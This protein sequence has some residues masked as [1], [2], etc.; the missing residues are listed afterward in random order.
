ML[1]KVDSSTPTEPSFGLPVEEQIKP[2]VYT[3][4][5]FKKYLPYLLSA[6]IL[7]V[8]AVLSFSLYQQ[9]SPQKSN[10]PINQITTSPAGQ[11][12]STQGTNVP[13]NQTIVGQQSLPNLPLSIN[14]VSKS[15]NKIT[16]KVDLQ[17]NSDISLGEVYLT[18]YLQ[19]PDEMQIASASGK[20]VGSIKEGKIYSFANTIKPFKLGFGEKTSQTIILSYSSNL[21]PNPDYKL[22]VF[23][24]GKYEQI[25]GS[26]F[27]NL[28]L[29]GTD[30]FLTTGNCRVIAEG[31]EYADTI[32]A[33]LI[34]PNTQ[35]QAKCSVTNPASKPIT[36]STNTDYAV[37]QVIG[38]PFSQ[39]QNMTDPIKF[40]LNPKETKEITVTLPKMSQPQ[41]YDSLITLIDENNQAVSQLLEFRWTIRGQ[42][43]NIE[44]VVL[45][46]SGYKAGDTAHLAVT[47]AASMDLWWKELKKDEGTSITNAKLTLSLIDQNNQVCGTKEQPLP[48]RDKTENWQI[49]SEIEITTDC[50]NPKVRA[51]IKNDSTVLASFS[52]Q[53]L[54]TKTKSD[55]PISS[56]LDSTKKNSALFLIPL[57][58]GV[59]LIVI[60]LAIAFTR[61][62]LFIISF[63]ALSFL[64]ISYL[65][66]H[67]II[68]A[69]PQNIQTSTI[70]SPQDRD[71]KASAGIQSYQFWKDNSKIEFIDP[72]T[73][74]LT[75]FY[76]AAGHWCNNSSLRFLWK[77]EITAQG[78]ILTLNDQL[79]YAISPDGQYFNAPAQD[80]SKFGNG[81]WQYKLGEDVYTITALN[82]LDKN[83]TPYSSFIDL[84]G[85]GS[86]GSDDR[87]TT[88]VMIK[89]IYLKLPTPII[90]NF[91]Q[92]FIALYDHN[93]SGTFTYEGFMENSYFEHVGGEVKDTSGK[94][95]PG[96]KMV[97]NGKE[98]T[99]DDKGQFYADYFV[100][101]GEGYSVR[102]EP[103]QGEF[104]TPSQ[105]PPSLASFEWQVAGEAKTCQKGDQCPGGIKNC[106]GDCHFVI[107]R[108][109]PPPSGGDSNPPPSSNT[110]QV[111]PP[112]S[113]NPASS[114]PA[115]P[116]P[117]P[118]P[119]GEKDP[120]VDIGAQLN[121]KTISIFWK[122]SDA[123]VCMASGNW[124]GYKPAANTSV[125]TVQL[126]ISEAKTYTYTLT[127]FNSTLT[128][129][130]SDTV[131]VTVRPGNTPPFIQTSGGDIHSN[132]GI[133][134]R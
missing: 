107:N 60:I 88:P 74:H 65:P 9:Q 120:G 72:T 103:G 127:C 61:G 52:R 40:S 34:N 32:S 125:Q 63:I 92:R 54:T 130:T 66:A 114:S 11:T 93:E 51:E 116:D 29:N 2:Q 117:N 94:I 20:T 126:A 39:K 132:E 18:A 82:E 95:A 131:F 73:I 68:S 21:P 90:S 101:N 129:S 49:T 77:P 56:T 113:S 17:N 14:V 122:T 38:Y 3:K 100:K 104:S 12:T 46:K 44:K 27:A 71:I 57:F 26:G 6:I 45:D 79:K 4:K 121:G 89:D 98:L 76:S 10:Q 41:V 97:V 37:R 15:D 99:T 96:I 133:D 70:F 86:H 87:I 5:S 80:F 53:D 110:P 112:N 124:V 119:D 78:N 62:G 115:N 36:F 35:A 48:P 111:S 30:G 75:I 67:N 83:N 81:I 128:R 118:D 24:D 105:D 109:G 91:K 1:D 43:A 123:S 25:L 134:A 106:G 8:S 23:V 42:S 47:A 59:L 31:K 7:L 33:P 85:G 50:T 108:S 22:I 28:T 19:G 55:Q 102:P 58:V 69:L 64:L 13:I 84:L 16:A